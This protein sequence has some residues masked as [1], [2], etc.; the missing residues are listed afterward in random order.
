MISFIKKLFG[1]G[2]TDTSVPTAAPYKIEPATT[3]TYVEPA[4][5]VFKPE[6]AATSTAPA[7]KNR[8][9]RNRNKAKA[10]APTAAKPAVSEGKTKGGNGAVKPAQVAKAK[11]AAPKA[12][13]L[14][15]AT[16]PANKP[17]QKSKQ[18]R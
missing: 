7:K 10:A 3:T 16:K 15:K 12:P 8:R 2:S 17:K 9:P 18:A 14:V 6:V 5:P 11:P 4:K 13:V 1:F